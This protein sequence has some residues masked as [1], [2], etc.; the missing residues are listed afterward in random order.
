MEDDATSGLGDDK[1]HLFSVG[2]TSGA[3]LRLSC[4]PPWSRS[5]RRQRPKHGAD[6]YSIV[7]MALGAAALAGSSLQLTSADTLR[8]QRH[9]AQV[10]PIRRSLCGLLSTP[11][12]PKCLMDDQQRMRAA[13]RL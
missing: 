3:T 7:P 4:H 12:V 11:T 1:S 9:R 13:V 6:I 5:D 10:A 8:R 2:E